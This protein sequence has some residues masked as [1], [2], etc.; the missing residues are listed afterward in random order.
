MADT[1]AKRKSTRPSKPTSRS[2]GTPGSGNGNCRYDSSLGLLTKKFVN[3]VEAAPDGVLDLN[4]AADAL[5]VQKRRIYDITNVLE[6][7]GLIEKKLK[8]NIQWKGGSTSDAAD[9]LPEQAA[10][11]QE[12]AH[13]QE[14]EQNLKRHIKALETS[15]KDMTEDAAN[16]ARLYVTDEDIAKLPCTAN[17]TVF[18]V[19]APQGTTLEVPDPDDGLETGQRRYRIV[20]KSNCDTPIDVWLVSGHHQQQQQEDQQVPLG[21][22]HATMAA[23]QVKQEVDHMAGPCDPTA[24]QFDGTLQ[25]D[26]SPPFATVH[27]SEP[28]PDAWYQ[29]SE[30]PALGIADYFEHEPDMI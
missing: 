2:P 12:V 18:A 5:A 23:V 30:P 11:R 17:D 3:L 26:A 15:I 19:K 1:S 25:I 27:N 6:G 10:L 22:P 24:S 20:L 21:H 14:D 8:N 28:D 29:H 9:N 4:K 7:I 13:L 16:S